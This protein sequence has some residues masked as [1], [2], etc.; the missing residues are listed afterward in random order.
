MLERAQARLDKNPN[1][2]RTRRETVEHP[3]GTLKMRMGA[4]HFLCKSIQPL[5]IRTP[6]LQIQSVSK[7]FGERAAVSDIIF[8]LYAHDW[9][10]VLGPSGAGKTTLFRCLAGLLRRDTGRVRF[11]DVDI[12]KLQLE[13][14]RR[15]AVVF[16]QYNLVQRLSALENVLGGRLGHVEAWRGISRRF[17]RADLL[18]AFE[19]LERVGMREHA[20]DRADRLSGGQQQRIAIARAL[21]EEPRLI[22]ADE[23]VASLDPASAAGVLL[24][25]R[26]IARSD[27]VAVICSLHQVGYART[28]ADQIIG[29]V[30]GRMIIDSKTSALT[31][32][33]FDALYEPQALPST[34]VTT[35][36]DPV[37]S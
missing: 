6:V 9:V 30:G 17:E 33:D 13:G 10:A 5:D 11:D 34:P 21:A 20:H 24:L 28:F 19:C 8:N 15:I 3:S 12:D 25:L 26:T 35:P 29:L 14:R 37:T 16:L 32:R 1:T 18:K 27:G 22:V 4:T 23:P 7:S 2:V 36:V 31:D